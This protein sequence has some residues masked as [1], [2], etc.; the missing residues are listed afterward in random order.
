MC[1]KAKFDITTPEGKQISKRVT[2]FKSVTFSQDKCDVRWDNNCFIGDMKTYHIKAEPVDGYGFDVVLESESSPWRGE[3]GHIGFEQNDE[4]YFTWLCVV[5]RGKVNCHGSKR[6]C[7]LFHYIF[8][9][10]LVD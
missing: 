10:D 1:Y 3:T 5:P 9:L 2:K 7:Q 4:K 8:L 6:K